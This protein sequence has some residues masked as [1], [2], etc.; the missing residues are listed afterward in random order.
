MPFSSPKEAP[1]WV[2]GEKARRGWMEA[3]NSAWDQHHDESKAHAIAASVAK[4]VMAEHMG[5]R[6]HEAPPLVIDLCPGPATV[7]AEDLNSKTFLKEILAEGRIFHPVAGKWL[8]WTKDRLRNLL[9][10]TQKLLALGNKV[11][12]YDGHPRDK[13]EESAK[14]NLGFADGFE[15]DE[16]GGKFRSKLFVGNPEY[17]RKIADEKTIA[18]VSVGVAHDVEMQDG[19]K[20]DEVIDHVALTN[21]PVM[22]KLGD[23]VALYSRNGGEPVRTAFRCYVTEEDSMATTTADLPAATP[24]V[25]AVPDTKTKTDDGRGLELEALRSQVKNLEANFAT[26]RK[27]RED[28]ERRAADAET[29]ADSE[30]FSRLAREVPPA[31]ADP[32]RVLWMDRKQ[33]EA[34]GKLLDAMKPFKTLLER[35][36]KDQGPADGGK[37]DGLKAAQA[38]AADQFDRYK[39]EG[40][41]VEWANDQKTSYRL[42]RKDGASKVFSVPV[43]SGE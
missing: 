24:A 22:S 43:E 15:F 29:R 10:N 7:S 12:I 3:F 41:N 33:R 35:K 36:S 20:L 2:K 31:L 14:A 34:A 23:F 32:L 25:A 9:G 38:R 42:T 13:A 27:V 26:E 17:A 1:E 19:S 6:G 11:P 8:E 39:R 5:A 37:V 4:K 16:A 28:L 21:Y 18:N 30:E 40:G